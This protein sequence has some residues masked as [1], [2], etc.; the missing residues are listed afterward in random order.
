MQFHWLTAVARHLRGKASL[1]ER[2]PIDDLF[3]RI[4]IK[5]VAQQAPRFKQQTWQSIEKISSMH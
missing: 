1:D 4:S 5:L 2:S 3:R